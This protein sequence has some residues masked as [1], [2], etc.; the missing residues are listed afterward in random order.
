MPEPAVRVEGATELARA[1]RQVA[2]STRDLS[3]AHRRIGREVVNIVRSEG[4]ATRQQSAAMRSIIGRGNARA[5]EVG[6]RNMAS[7][8]FGIGAFMGSLAY[9]QFPAWV[10]NSWSLIDGEGP[11][12]FRDAFKR[13]STQEAI[14]AAF[15]D[16]IEAVLQKAGI[17]TS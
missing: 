9:P 5:A 6:L 3:A 7:V 11:Y 12:V 17:E 16:E 10:G 14:E 13:L 15:L 8:P 4:G 2:G 1:F